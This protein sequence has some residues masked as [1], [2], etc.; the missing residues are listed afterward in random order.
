MERWTKIEGTICFGKITDDQYAVLMN[1]LES[2]DYVSDYR[3][4]RDMGM[5]MFPKDAVV[6]ATPNGSTRAFLQAI[7]KAVLPKENSVVRT[8][9]SD[10]EHTKYLFVNESWNEYHGMVC[11]P[12]NDDDP[13]YE[14][15]MVLYNRLRK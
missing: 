12:E 7:T 8:F 9:T 6:T 10:G 2:G 13:D 14:E 11:Y 1:I 5:L 3:F 4:Q 15:L